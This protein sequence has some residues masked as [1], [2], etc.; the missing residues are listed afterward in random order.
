[1]SGARAWEMDTL[2]GHQNNVSCVAFH[3]KL[4]ILISN[5]EDRTMKVW[6][7]NRRTCIYT[8]KKE[9]DRFWVVAMHPTSNYFACGYDR[10]MT[11]FKLESERFDY[12]RIGN[13]LF[14]VKNKVLMMED[15]T[16][17]ESLPQANL[18]IE[19]KQVLMN[20]P[21]T[22]FYNHF[23]NSNH[24]IIL[25]YEGEEGFSI[26]VLVNKN[27]GKNSNVVQRKIDSTK[28]GV[29][30]AKDKI[31]VLSKSKTLFIY[32]FDGRNKK[33]DWT[34]K[35]PI[36]KIFQATIGKILIK[37]GDDV[38]LFDIAARKIINEVQFANL[39]RVYW[40]SNMSYVALC[41]KNVVMIC[42]KNL[43]PI[44][45]MKEATKIK[46]GCFDNENGFIYSTSS[47]IKYLLVSE[48]ANTSTG[49]DT[50]NNSG[51]FKSTDNPV[52]IC[53]FVNNSVFYINREGKVVREEVNTAEYELK[54]ALKRRKIKEVIKILN[55]GQ[56]SGNAV[57]QYLKE[58]NCADI[59]L[60]FEKDPKTRFSLALS[61]G[62][63]QEAYKNAAEIKEKDTYLQLGEQA[64]LQGYMN[65]TEKSYQSIK[66]FSKLSFFY[67][68]QGCTSKLKKM[69][70]IAKDLNNKNDIF[71]NSILLGS[72]RDRVKLLVQSG[73]IALAY[74][75]AKAHNLK[76]LIP[77]IE[78]EMRNR[79]LILTDDFEEQLRERTS[80]AKSLLPCRPVFTENEEFIT[81]NWPHTM[82]LQSNVAGEDRQEEK[83]YDATATSKDTGRDISDLLTSFK[84]KEHSV[85]PGFE[86]DL[87]DVG[88]TDD[89]DAI[90]DEQ[91]IG[92]DQWGEEIELDDDIL[93]D[94]GADV[95]HG[96]PDLA[97][98]DREVNQEE[99]EVFIPPTRSN[100][101]II[102][103]V[104]SSMIPAHHI[105]LGNFKE[106]LDLLR[107]QI[108]L[109]NPR[110]LR[111]IFAFIH[112]CSKISIPSLP[113][114][115]SL[116]AILRSQDGKTPASIINHEFLKK[117]YKE[118][119]NET[120]KGNFKGALLAFQKCIQYAT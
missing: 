31:C 21:K 27:Q 42:N 37:S 111:S 108:G 66:A 112:T 71:E 94:M 46:S 114:C 23:D 36:N 16:N 79:E 7:L 18:E 59:A 64:L 74:M 80:K 38:L 115:P 63:I 65:V 68:N 100:D 72:V 86:D 62:N 35:N 55:K 85:E 52:Y 3:P 15:L 5:S 110:P 120:T 6:D 96:D 106:A 11:I 12:E 117:L 39:A 56:L 67:A 89:L 83:F 88:K 84:E 77:L 1:M 105:A 99:D 22:L 4:E 30:I 44:C 49:Q 10:G 78:E 81:A 98:L 92:N 25:N 58:E 93:G 43:K 50:N 101:P 53:G 13:Q 32:L 109:S 60:L 82:L 103:L 70:A 40:S 28:G 104:S 102:Q 97:D 87:L 90:G 8:L 29:F 24:D 107:K 119:F 17:M 14:Y 19:G 113:K 34:L 91:A 116:Q 45:T 41:S 48:K 2:R 54:V 26:L 73:Q 76:D 51:I 75:S 95:T 69:Q 118:G 33:I 9:V 57:I 20:Q 61:S 47:H